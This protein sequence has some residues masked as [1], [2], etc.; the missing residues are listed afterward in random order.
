M[1]IQ[2]AIEA[3]TSSRQL[4]NE[5][6]GAKIPRIMSDWYSTQGLTTSLDLLDALVDGLTKIK[7]LDEMLE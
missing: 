5:V 7:E 6:Q 2:E 4:I 3:L 1:T